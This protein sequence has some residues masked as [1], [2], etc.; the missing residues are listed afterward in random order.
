MSKHYSS[1][2]PDSV[3]RAIKTMSIEEIADQYGIEISDDGTIYDPMD[4]RQFD[5]IVEWALYMDEVEQQ[6]MFAASYHGNT[7]YAFDDD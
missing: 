3:T 7:R 6:A 4:Q 5:S 2:T 1:Y